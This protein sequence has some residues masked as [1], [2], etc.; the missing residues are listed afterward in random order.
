M[1]RPILGLIFLG[2][3]RFFRWLALFLLG[4]LLVFLLHFLLFLIVL[5]L[6]LFELLLL[7]LLDLLL[8]L[9][10]SFLLLEFFLF[11]SLLLLNALTFLVLLLAQPFHFLLLALLGLRVRALAG[12]RRTVVA[13]RRLVRLRRRRP[14]RRI[15]IGRPVIVRLR[16]LWLPRRL[17][18]SR[19]TIRVRLRG[20]RLSRRLIRGRAIRIRLRCRRLPRA[21]RVGIRGRA[22]RRRQCGGLGRSRDFH[23]RMRS[24][25]LRLRRTGLRNGGRTSAIGLH[26]LNLLTHGSGRRWWRRLGDDRPRD[27][28]F[29]RTN[30]RLRCRAGKAPLLGS[31]GRRNGGDRSAG[32]FLCVDTYQVLRNGLG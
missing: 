32:D 6:Q 19:R 24:G 15:G 3:L 14:I 5:A 17:I 30:S 26:R 28:V 18:R 9:F 8:T 1:W 12:S 31:D 25:C 29:R 10:I 27:H 11:L 13:I 7:A 20:L 2:R 23:F 21:I 16:R 4:F 22:P